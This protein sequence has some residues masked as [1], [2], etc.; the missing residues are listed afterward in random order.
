MIDHVNAYALTVRDVKKCAEFYRDKLGFRLQE[1]QD[2]FAYLK[3]GD[4]PGAGLA[5]VSAQGLALEIPPELV[6]P[7]ERRVQRNYFAV[8]LDDA[9][10]VYEELTRKGV[11]FVQPP[12]TRSNGQR[13]A[14]FQDPEGNLWEISHFPKE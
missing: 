6:R 10:R 12:A 11:H 1:L 14:F 8:F 13:F 7:A 9:D 2:G 5:L 3:F 4:T